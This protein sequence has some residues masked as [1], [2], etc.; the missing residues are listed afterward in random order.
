[1]N[2]SLLLVAALTGRQKEQESTQGMEGAVVVRED[3]K[4]R[5]ERG[6][7]VS[8]RLRKTRR[9]VKRTAK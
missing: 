5:D 7:K 8:R 1:M 9:F 6:F 4:S 2:R 3:E